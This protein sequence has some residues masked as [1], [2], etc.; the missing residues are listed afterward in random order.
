MG[1]RSFTLILSNLW[2]S[3]NSKFR[4]FLRYFWLKVVHLSY[5]VKLFHCKTQVDLPSWFRQALHCAFLAASAGR[6]LVNGHGNGCRGNSIHWGVYGS[7][8]LEQTVE[9]VCF[10]L[11]LLAH[12][13]A[14]LASRII[15]VS[16]PSCN[17]RSNCDVCESAARNSTGYILDL[18]FRTI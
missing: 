13:S 8:Q 9:I 2:D 12:S 15:Q 18:L 14:G 10:P 11:R 6:N 17:A 7:S 16:R 3:L 4:L 1:M 5:S